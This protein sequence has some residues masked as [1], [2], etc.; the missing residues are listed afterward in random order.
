MSVC[1]YI[2]FALFS[3]VQTYEKLGVWGKWGKLSSFTKYGDDVI[4]SFLEIIN[5]KYYYKHIQIM[6]NVIFY[7][8]L[9]KNIDD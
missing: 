9:E 3:Y 1:I 4:F 7:Y 8:I 2:K 6:I 5:H